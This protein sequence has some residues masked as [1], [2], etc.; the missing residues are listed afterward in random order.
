MI[1]KIEDMRENKVNLNIDKEIKLVIKKQ[2][3]EQFNQFSNIYFKKIQKNIK[4][5]E[6]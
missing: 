6:L 1:L 3:N 5:N 4:I 2:T